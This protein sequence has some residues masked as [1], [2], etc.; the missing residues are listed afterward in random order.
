MS[1]RQRSIPLRILA[2]TAL[3]VALASAAKLLP[4][5]GDGQK[6]VQIRNALIYEG[7]G[8]FDWSPDG[9]PGWF[10]T[11]RS[12]APGYLQSTVADLGI[13]VARGGEFR[14]ALALALHLQ[15]DGRRKSGMIAS[16]I[17]STYQKMQE[18][19]R[20]YCADYTLVFT[21]LA[22]AAGVPVREWG[23][24]FDD[25]SGDGHAFTEI[26]DSEQDQWIFLDTFN[27]F[28]VE[29]DGGR[30]L[31]FLQF[32]RALL[33]D[34][35]ETLNVIRITPV[36]FQFADDQ[37]ALDYYRRGVRLAFLWTGNDVFS[38]EASGVVRSLAGLPRSVEQLV[39]IF[40]GVHPRIMLDL[41]DADSDSLWALKTVR[42]AIILLALS[43]LVLFV[44][45]VS[46]FVGRL[47]ARRRLAAPGAA[48]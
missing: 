48:A 31:S 13:D 9:A 12:A 43:S 25:Y 23:M 29:D 2:V 36:D 6:M 21:A 41:E 17:A 35:D 26:Y 3:L 5:L 38:Y 46:F 44:L 19:G 39:A 20:G 33:D 40:A 14:D 1:S 47:R 24:S 11:E 32:K 42:W 30:P 15:P 8:R 45:V 37:M 10:R 34:A 7:G 27:G 28:Y 18:S 16:D 22:H 4:L